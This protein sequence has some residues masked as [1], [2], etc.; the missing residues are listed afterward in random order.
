MVGDE[1]AAGVPESSGDAWYE[2]RRAAVEL[3]DVL[4]AAG[5][6]R[7]FPFLQADV[8][9][10]GHGFVNLG[11]TTPA[12]TQQLAYLL[13]EARKAMGDQA[14]AGSSSPKGRR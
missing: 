14:F 7:S 5:L 10:F 13:N 2:A 6:A 3:R 8:N 11:R 12:A 4:A 9:V 1:E